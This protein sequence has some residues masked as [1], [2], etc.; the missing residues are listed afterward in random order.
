M[1]NKKLKRI[2]NYSP[3]LTQT[4]KATT[5]THNVDHHHD[6]PAD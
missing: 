4:N 6:A 5:N 2:F 1:T 3:K